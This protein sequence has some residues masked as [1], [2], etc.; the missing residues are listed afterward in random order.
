MSARERVAHSVSGSGSAVSVNCC[1]LRF[2]T[3]HGRSG[4]DHPSTGRAVVV[5]VHTDPQLWIGEP[6]LAHLMGRGDDPSA[7]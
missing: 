2:V 6:T 3:C 4:R 7:R 5:L 1:S